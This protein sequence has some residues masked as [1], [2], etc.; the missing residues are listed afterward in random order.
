MIRTKHFL[1]LVVATLALSSAL[2]FPN[3]EVKADEN[4]ASAIFATPKASYAATVVTN[5]PSSEWRDAFIAKVRAAL[6][7]D[8][9][10]RPVVSPAP[11][12]LPT[13]E[14]LPLLPASATETPGTTTEAL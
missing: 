10:S 11:A 1:I 9:L 3:P 5:E 4:R 13:P 12:P 6:R 14:P 8:E 7:R 2:A